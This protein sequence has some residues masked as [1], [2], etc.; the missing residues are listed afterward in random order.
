MHL[1]I[2][3]PFCKQACHYCNF[4]FSTNL[5][6]K[7]AMVRAICREIEMQRDYLP[8]KALETIYFGGGT[9]SLLSEKELTDIFRTIQA[10]FS[11]APDAEITLE[12]NP[13][14][15][16]EANLGVLKK[17]VN[18]LSIGIQTFDAATLLKMNRAHNAKQSEVCV[19][20]AQDAG[21]ENISVDL[22][23]G[24]GAD[25]ENDLSKTLALNVPHVSAYCLTIETK[26][27][28]G[29]QQKSGHRPPEDE[30]RSVA[31][32]E[33]L[34]NTLTQNGY[35]QYEIC[36]F[37]KPN[38]YS[39]HNSAYWQREPYLGVGP[40][41]HSYNGHS[42]QYNVANNARYIRAVEAGRLEFEI[43][44]LSLDNQVND[45]ILTGLRTS[46]GCDLGVI[47]ALVG[48]RWQQQQRATLE[49]Y[50]ERD[51]LSRQKNNIVLTES[52][53]LFADRIASD[54]FLV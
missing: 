30:E 26:T 24:L 47:R 15:L 20:V 37:A 9:P 14:D 54:L 21:F 12:A 42:R 52:G 46:W 2:H 36:S 34:V 29:N 32:F 41:A 8:A 19:K 22:M 38:R 3:I 7:A 40:S 25:F 53:K 28:W 39:V 49:N 23:Y 44:Q 48:E 1:Y 5:Q 11:I 50:I 10:C 16:V 13:D 35:E 45:Y 17:F 33:S 31:E 27:V 4:H 18:R 6:N 51:Y 43:E